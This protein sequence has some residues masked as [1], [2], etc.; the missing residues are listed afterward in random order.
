MAETIVVGHIDLSFHDAAAR[1]VEIILEENGHAVMR[2]TAHHE[3]AFRMLGAG[4]I[5][6]LCA[7]WLPSSHT[8][9]LNPLLNQVTKV[10]VLYEPY[11]IWGVPHYVP[12]DDV[13]TVS[14]LLE[15]VAEQKM[16]RLIQGINPGAG[17]SRFSKAMVKEYGLNTLGYHFNP[18]TE[19]ECFQRFIDAYADRRW[20]VIPLWHPQW[21]HNR[22]RIRALDE[23]KGLLGGRDEATLIM[24]ND[25][26]KKLASGVLDKLKKLYLG[27]SKVSELDDLIQKN[28]Q[29]T[30][31]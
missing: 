20:I 12:E 3:E 30:K 19:Q 31:I 18:G 10:T 16:E 14:D 23:P 9:Y 6:F 17:I 11:C 8:M 7:A 29:H 5:D 1:E 28:N 13:S 26:E 24:R 15:P 4:E 25:A 2:K 22:Y 21:L 27:N